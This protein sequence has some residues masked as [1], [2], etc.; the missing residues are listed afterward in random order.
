MDLSYITMVDFL[1]RFANSDDLIRVF[2]E[3]P[4]MILGHYLLIQRWQIKFFP[5][6]GQLSKVVVW[7][8][9]RVL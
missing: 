9:N 6:E 2:E 8:A 4:W 1:I 7:S 5:H 3:G